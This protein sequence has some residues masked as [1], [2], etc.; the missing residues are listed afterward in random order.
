MRPS[1]TVHA[2]PDT[3]LCQT[4]GK[5]GAD[6]LHPLIRVEDQRLTLL[7]CVIQAVEAKPGLQGVGEP[8]RQHPRQISLGQIVAAFA[9]GNLFAGTAG[10]TPHRQ[11]AAR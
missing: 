3:R 7:Q 1:P 9:A 6:E 11:S 8:P 4:P 5:R 2:N 10:P